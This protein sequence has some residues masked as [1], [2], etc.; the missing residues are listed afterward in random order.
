MFRAWLQMLQQ[1]F[2][3]RQY[4]LRALGCAYRNLSG[5][6]ISTWLV[7][8][9]HLHLHLHLSPLCQHGSCR[10]SCVAACLFTMLLPPWHCDST[11]TL[12]R[13]HGL[14]DGGPVCIRH[15]GK[16]KRPSVCLT[17]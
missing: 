7:N 5:M 13:L 8:Y 14:L 17:R 11:C 2:L 1:H 9:L 6:V 3:R 12:N 4:A 15:P 16:V 10:N